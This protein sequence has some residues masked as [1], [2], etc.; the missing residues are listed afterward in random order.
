MTKYDDASWH[1][2]GDFPPE[3]DSERACTHI[4]LFLG[5]AVDRGL[6]GDLLREEYGE[7]L[8]GFRARRLSPIELLHAAA[9]DKLTDEDLNDEGN[10]FTAEYFDSNLYYV[11]YAMAL[12]G[13]LPSLYHVDCTWENY[14]RMAKR[15]DERLAEWRSKRRLSDRN[16]E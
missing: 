6:G 5:W 12:A 3:L 8:E 15:I 13:D 7:M 1:A 2:G 10:A 4:A 11:D 14:D 9:D 16:G